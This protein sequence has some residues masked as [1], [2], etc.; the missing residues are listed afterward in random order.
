MF[1]SR[2]YHRVAPIPVSSEEIQRARN[3]DWRIFLTPE[4]PIPRE[5]FPAFRDTEFLF[6]DSEFQLRNSI[7]LCGLRYDGRRDVFGNRPVRPAVF[8]QPRDR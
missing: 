4:K 7:K 8:K 1:L 6:S 2:D 5:W 3:D